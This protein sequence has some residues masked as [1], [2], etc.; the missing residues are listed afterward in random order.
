[1]G[2]EDELNMEYER[3]ALEQAALGSLSFR[4]QDAFN[5]GRFYELTRKPTFM[6]VVPE[7]ELE[8]WVAAHEG[9][10]PIKQ[11]PWPRDLVNVAS[12]ARK[13]AEREG[14]VAFRV[15][16]NDEQ[17]VD[18][19]RRACLSLGYNLYDLYGDH[20]ANKHLFHFL[21]LVQA[22][23]AQ[24]KLPPSKR[25]GEQKMGPLIDEA[26]KKWGF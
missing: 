1:M 5:L 11:Y 7:G 13:H 17:P 26:R 8:K 2:C 21:R 24:E 6:P 22:S 18:E 4:P 23:R 16:L 20:E 25:S 15:S 12:W 9:K 14:I 10:D 19:R 3:G